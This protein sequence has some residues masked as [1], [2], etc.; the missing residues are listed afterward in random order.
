MS[1]MIRIPSF[2]ADIEVGI[3]DAGERLTLEVAGDAVRLGCVILRTD[4]EKLRDALI[5]LLEPFALDEYGQPVF[6]D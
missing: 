1:D 6:V 3:D 2:E 4:A 5:E